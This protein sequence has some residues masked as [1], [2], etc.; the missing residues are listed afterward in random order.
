MPL[1][2]GHDCLVVPRGGG[3]VNKLV[4]F[5]VLSS[6]YRS[7]YL[8]ILMP[9]RA[10]RRRTRPVGAGPPSLSQGL[11]LPSGPLPA[12]T[13]TDAAALGAAPRRRRRRF[14]P[15]RSVLFR[16]P[17]SNGRVMYGLTRS[18]GAQAR[19]NLLSVWPV[20]QQGQHS[21]NLFKYKDS[22][23]RSVH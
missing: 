7:H 3:W 1:W 21:S 17:P 8:P 14:I 12:A 18:Y 15:P 9:P 11:R 20:G 23:L 19:L 6:L 13:V 22:S 5:S 2:Y 16:F 4:V 10:P